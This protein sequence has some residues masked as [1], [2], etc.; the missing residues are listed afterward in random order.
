MSQR[1]TYPQ[2]IEFLNKVGNLLSTQQQIKQQDVARLITETSPHVARIEKDNIEKALKFNVFSALGVTRK[3]VIQSRFLAY[4]LDPNEHHIQSSIFLDAFLMKIGLPKI[5]KEQNNRVR[6]ATEHSTGEGLGRMDIVLFC[7]P[8]WLVVIENKVD[9]GEAEQQLPRYAKW[10]DKQP[11]YEFKKLI[12]LTPTGH[13]SVTA[14]AGDCV[15]LSYLDLA[16]AFAPRLNQIKAESVRFVVAQ[17]ITICKLIG[18]SDVTTQDKQVLDLLTKPENIKIALEIEQ[19]TQL[20]RRQ[21]AE[22]FVENILKNIQIKLETEKLEKNWKAITVDKYWH[23]ESIMNIEIRTLKPQT[24]PNYKMVAEYLFSLQ[25]DKCR[26]GWYRPQSLNLK[27]QMLS[28][29]NTK[30]LTYKMISDGCNDGDG[31]WVGSKYFP[32]GKRG[33]VLTDI[34]DIV[35]CLQDNRTKVH[36]LANSIADEL[37]SMFATY[38]VDIE[39]LDSFKQVA[40]L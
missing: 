16:E 29:L 3:E 40:S 35:V 2:H 36:F 17:Y 8:D 39:M 14:K 10:L 21:V 22:K 13:E 1:N 27:N 6:V 31:N 9:A 11:G 25:K 18:G 38:R 15:Q 19:Q 4:L 34:D 5:S 32:Y 24:K 23:K 7:Q 12:F 26:S 20:L 28:T 30:D 37:W 33:F